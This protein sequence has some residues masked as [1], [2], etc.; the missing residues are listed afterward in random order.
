MD[1]VTTAIVLAAAAGIASGST[2]VGEAVIVD[3][4]TTLKESLRYKFGTNSKLLEAVNKIEGEPDYAPNKQ[5]VAGRVAQL[6]ADKDPEIVKLAQAVI[7]KL[8]AKTTPQ[9]S[10]SVSQKAG[11]HAIQVGRDVVGGIHTNR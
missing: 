9:G 1:P 6:Q 5:D 3:A 2:K 11:D 8:E 7:A 10:A 4:Y